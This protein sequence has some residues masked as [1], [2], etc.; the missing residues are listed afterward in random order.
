MTDDTRTMNVDGFTRKP[1]TEADRLTIVAEF[2]R[3][4]GLVSDFCKSGR[5]NARQAAI[6]QNADRKHRCRHR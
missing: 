3:W 6:A 5:F 1:W 2:G 4:E